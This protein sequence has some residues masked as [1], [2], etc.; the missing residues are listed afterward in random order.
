MN[1]QPIYSIRAIIWTTFLTGPLGGFIALWK[2]F[3]AFGDGDS[4]FKT[5][6]VGVGVTVALFIFY[7]FSEIEISFF[8]TLTNIIMTILL[9][10]VASRVQGTKIARYLAAGGSKK[11]TASILGLMVLSVVIILL[12]ATALVVVFETLGISY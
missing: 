3:R 2:N 7:I 1:R 8:Y 6:L 9:G 4:A 12:I 10:T 11:S 5:I